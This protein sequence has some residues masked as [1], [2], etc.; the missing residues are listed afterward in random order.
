MKRIFAILLALALS[1]VFSG[2]GG[3]PNPRVP[4]K[5]E[6]KPVV[7]NNETEASD[8]LESIKS[9]FGS[10]Y[11]FSRCN[12]TMRMKDSAGN[13][14]EMRGAASLSNILKAAL[15]AGERPSIQP[16]D[17]KFDT[18]YKVEVRWTYGK[19][20]PS[21]NIVADDGLQYTKDVSCPAPA[22]P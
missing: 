10:D 20:L 7:I 6:G 16:A 8:V 19:T 15:I 5:Y 9:Q 22:A 12:L 17:P 18:R 21:V 13:L 3:G 11:Y 14:V 1:F 2:C 4:L